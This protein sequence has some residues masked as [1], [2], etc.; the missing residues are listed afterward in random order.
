LRTNTFVRVPTDLLEAL[1]RVRLTETGWRIVL[2][3]IRQTFG[4]N[5]QTV[6]YSWYRIARDL[7]MDRG[8]VVRT[9]NSLLRANV[10]HIREA[11]LGLQQNYR[12]WDGG[13]YPCRHDHDGQLWMPG[14]G[15]DGRHRT[16]MTRISASDDDS[17]RNRCHA[18]SVFRRAIDSSKDKIKI[19]KDRPAR[20]RDAAHGGASSSGTAERRPFAGAAKPIA[21]KYDGVSL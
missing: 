18:S 7:S 19:Y 5:R 15:A 2:W 8:G 13:I 21:G 16:P 9:G 17:H 11:R 4:W 3:V 20:L 6:P 14:L 10:L 12:E 1:L